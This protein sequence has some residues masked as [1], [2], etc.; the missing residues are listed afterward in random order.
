MTLEEL[1]E[2]LGEELEL[3]RIEPKGQRSSTHERTATTASAR[4]P[5]SLRHFKRTYREAL[6]AADRDREIS[7]PSDPIVIPDPRDK[8]YRSWKPSRDR[9]PTR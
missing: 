1:A 5:E 6:R 9:R 7:T 2:M 3:P 8:R 4:R